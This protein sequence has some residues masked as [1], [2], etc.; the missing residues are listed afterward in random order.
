MTL[1]ISATR[2][3]TGVRVASCV[4]KIDGVQKVRSCQES[5]PKL[6]RSFISNVDPSSVS[7]SY[8]PSAS[9]SE[10]HEAALLTVRHFTCVH[11]QGTE[12]FR[13]CSGHQSHVSPIVSSTQAFTRLPILLSSK[14]RKLMSL[15]GTQDISRL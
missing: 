8:E 9:V 6:L 13:G 15:G 10:V 4:A 3:H 1:R 11:P 7:A 12:C 14:T 2:M 5:T